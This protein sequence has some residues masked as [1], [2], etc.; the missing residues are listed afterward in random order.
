MGVIARCLSSK[1]C[2][3]LPIQGKTA[4]DIMVAPAITASLHLSVSDLSRMLKDHNINRLPIVSDDGS[5]VGI[6][7]R[8]DIVNS[9]CARI[10]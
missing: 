4:K 2:V 8:G 5:L 6:V 7:S 10:F 3:A 1:G 9:Y